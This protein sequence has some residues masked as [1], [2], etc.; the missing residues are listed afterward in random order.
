MIAPLWFDFVVPQAS[1]GA[2]GVYTSVVGTEPERTFIVEWREVHKYQQPTN[3]AT[4]ELLLSENGIMTF[5]YQLLTEPSTRGSEGVVG[6]QNADGTVGLPYSCYEAALAPQRAIRYQLVPDVI[7]S[8]SASQRGGAPRST[9]TYSQTLFNQTGME[10]SFTIEPS[11]NVWT[12]TVQ[13]AETGPVPNG[14]RVPITVSVQIPPD[15]PIGAQDVATITA[16]SELPSRGAFTATAVLTSSVTSY[17]VDFDPPG[18]T[19][20][21]RYGSTVT[22]TVQITNRSGI[23]NTFDL[24]HTGNQWPT[25]VTPSQVSGIGPDASSPVTITVSVPADATLA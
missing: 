16:I 20:S 25:S 22:Y 15:A 13:P 19:R 17:G 3:R 1:S 10:N 5:Q 9:L 7:L 4:F 18:L 11:G 12:T 6:I 8:P 24:S 14:G 21:G 2:A 23:T